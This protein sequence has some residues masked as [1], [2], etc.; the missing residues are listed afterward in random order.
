VQSVA[1]CVAQEYG[2]TGPV[3]G[4][5]T[6]KAMDLGYTN[7]IPGLA[8]LKAIGKALWTSVSLRLQR[9]SVDEGVPTAVC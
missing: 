9:K 4:R 5:I 8:G 3:F 2:Q 1:F 7:T 6:Q